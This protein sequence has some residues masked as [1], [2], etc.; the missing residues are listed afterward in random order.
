M[1]TAEPPR[2][3]D[4]SVV[5]GGV[6]D[7]RLAGLAVAAW[8]AALAGLHATVTASATLAAVAAGLALLTG[9][10]LGGLLGPPAGPVRRY[11]W[12]AVAVLLGVVC[13]ATATAARIAVRDAAPVRALVA[14]RTLV[15]AELVVRDDPRPIRGAAGR[16]AT[17]LVSADLIRL[18]DPTGRQVTGTVSSGSVRGVV[19]TIQRG[20]CPS[21]SS[22]QLVVPNGG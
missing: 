4:G 10:H 9:A 3:V 19:P 6:P 21:S 14:E 2:D 11:G 15:T 20:S 22:P 17:L 5:D 12:I 8:L 16:P 1:N 18:T 13:G 7:L